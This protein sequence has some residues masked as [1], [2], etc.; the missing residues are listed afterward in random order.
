MKIKYAI[1]DVGQT[2]YP[3]T[4]KPL[5]DYMQERTSEPELFN[6][7]HTVFNYDYK[8]Y[9]KGEITDEEFAH[10]LCFFC[11]VPYNN[12]ILP[13]INQ[14]LHAGC[15][16]PFKETITAMQELKEANI[17]IGI[18]SNALP[19]LH[20]TKINLVPKKYAFTSY[21]L[22]SLKPDCQIYELLAQ[23]LNASYEEI[24]F[25]DDKEK[26]ITTANQLGIN[27]I[28]YN[29]D[30]ILQD[31]NSYLPENLPHLSA[32]VKHTVFDHIDMNR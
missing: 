9:M 18:L 19:I 24:L 27:G 2:I 20:D 13:I 28:V 22:K 32:N 29:R 6:N 7:R 11:R 21:E 23:K 10:E 30:T 4:L 26:N 25:I 14:K 3:F 31:I 1:F 8:P 5:N 16:K 15:G 17:K 12:T